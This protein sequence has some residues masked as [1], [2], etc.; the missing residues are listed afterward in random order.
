MEPLVTT[1]PR[2]PADRSGGQVR[3]WFLDATGQEQPIPLT[4]QAR[5][6]RR[7]PQGTITAAP[8]RRQPWTNTAQVSTAGG[9]SRHGPGEKHPKA[10]LA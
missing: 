9:L 7:R 2:K 4:K 10:A 6:L 5:H 1:T 8:D 3:T